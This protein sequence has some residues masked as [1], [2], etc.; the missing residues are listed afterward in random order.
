MDTNDSPN[1]MN[2]LSIETVGWKKKIGKIEGIGLSKCARAYA[3][4]I[5]YEDDEIILH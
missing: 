4:T 5:K 2:A 3:G 1:K